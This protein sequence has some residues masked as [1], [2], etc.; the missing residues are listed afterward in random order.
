MIHVIASVRV[1]AGR[2]S[3][4]LEIMKS[5]V[6]KVREESGCIEYSPTLDSDAGLLQQRLEEN[7]VT[8][9]EK[10]ESLEALQDHFNATHMKAYLEKVKDMVE[11]VSINVLREA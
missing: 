1:K 7:V 8:I 4:Y 2:I 9:I 11:D 3:E 10:W 6:P 5:N